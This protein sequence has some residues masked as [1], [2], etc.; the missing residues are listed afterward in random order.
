MELLNEYKIRA[1]KTG[2]FL[3]QNTLNSH[4]LLIAEAD[5]L[6]WILSSTQHEDPVMWFITIYLYWWSCLSSVLFFLFFSFL[7]RFEFMSVCFMQLFVMNVDKVLYLRLH[8][9][10]WNS[11]TYCIS[12]CL[13]AVEHFIRVSF[14][15]APSALHAALYKWRDDLDIRRILEVKLNKGTVILRC[16]PIYHLSLSFFFLVGRHPLFGNMNLHLFWI[17]VYF[18]N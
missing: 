9:L 5:E 16:E 18:L 17:N 8:A 4:F 13:R 14:H 6:C 1:A 12:G 3:H 2:H 10:Q 15:K 11:V 7:L